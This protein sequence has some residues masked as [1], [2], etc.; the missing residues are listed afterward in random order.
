M[1]KIFCQTPRVAQIKSGSDG[2]R[3]SSWRIS[4]GTFLLVTGAFMLAFRHDSGG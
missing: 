3:A 1:E 2:W 4:S